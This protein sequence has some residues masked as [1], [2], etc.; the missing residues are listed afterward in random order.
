[1][2]ALS[3]IFALAKISSPPLVILDEVD[4]FLDVE[5]VQYITNY[6]HKNRKSQI[7]IVSHKE[8]L[9]SRSNSLIGVCANKTELTS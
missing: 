5:N 2:A 6:L 1:M 4:A 3:F 9:A 7:L 8:E